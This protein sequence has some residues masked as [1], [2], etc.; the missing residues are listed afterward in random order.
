MSIN[1]Q[2]MINSRQQIRTQNALLIAAIE[3]ILER[4]YDNVSVTAIADRANYGRSTFYVYFKD[5]AAITLAILQRQIDT[6]EADIAA[7]VLDLRFPEREARA[8]EMIF[9]RALA[10][11]AFFLQLRG[12]TSDGLRLAQ[13][14]YLIQSFEKGIASGFFQNPRPQQPVPLVARFLTGALQEVLDYWLQNPHLGTAQEMAARFVQMVY[15]ME[16]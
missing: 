15:Y 8:W 6:L 2:M 14:A 5:K 7:A 16:K 1:Q 9:E 11:A 3:L 13:Q 12:D 4:G 10:Q